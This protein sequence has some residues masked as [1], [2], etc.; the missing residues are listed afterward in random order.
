MF[1]IGYSKFAPG[2]I[3][4]FITC[5]IYII[6]F[7]F[8]IQ[9][10]ILL[11]LFIIILLSSFFAIESLKNYFEEVDSKEIVIDEFIGQ[12][13][14][15]LTLY[16]LNI[17]NDLINFIFLSILSFLL[18]RFFDI[19]KPYPINIIDKNLKNNLGVI[20]DDI[21]AGLFSVITLLILNTLLINVF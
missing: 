13:I 8:K 4:S 19:L 18:F 12:S 3:A 9:I 14:P 16:Y 2:T 21:I 6:L 1:G 17:S 7:F 15:L 5:L 10:F 11:S 20:L